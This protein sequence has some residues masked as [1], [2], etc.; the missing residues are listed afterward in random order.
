MTSGTGSY[1]DRSLHWYRSTL[2]HNAPMIDGHSQA[3]VDGSL[4]AHEERG[5]F[6]WTFAE[7][8]GL[9]PGVRV[10]RAV[11]V[12]PD[13]F[14]DEIRWSAERSVQFDLPIHLDGE[15]HGVA[16]DAGVSLDG[17]SGLEDG[18]DFVRNVNAAAVLAGQ[19]VELTG[20]RGGNV[21]RAFVCPE[22]TSR[23]FR[24]DGPGQPAHETRPFHLVRCEGSSG[25]IRGVW[26]WSSRLG[27]VRFSGGRL[28][29]ALG[30]ERH[31]H[32]LTD[33]GWEI[34]VATGGVRTRLELKGW[35]ASRPAMT[36]ER[37]KPAGRTSRRDERRRTGL[38]ND[39]RFCCAAERPCRS[40]SA[41]RT[42]DVPRS[43][44][45]MP[46]ARARA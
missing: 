34:D 23:W 40:N 26:T 13:Y 2:A 24:A 19:P 1:V 36:D 7:A 25:S 3:R 10:T 44:G 5:G 29:I 41:R 11:V 46:G 12:T 43:R 27:A 32:Q 15:L 45:T 8:N 6:G 4:L 28:E 21:V 39:L 20:E 35:T 16:L 18:F 31:V 9:A 33:A 42:I 38:R 37:G 22:G 30:D 17:G 14:V